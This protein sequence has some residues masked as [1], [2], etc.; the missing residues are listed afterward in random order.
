[1]QNNIHIFSI[2][3]LVSFIAAAVVQASTAIGNATTPSGKI[4]YVNESWGF[5]LT[6]G[7]FDLATGVANQMI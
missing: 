4:L 7:I 3:I 1:M 6:L 2:P 5:N